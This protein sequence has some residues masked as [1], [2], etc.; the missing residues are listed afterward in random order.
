MA[1]PVFQP[2]RVEIKYFYPGHNNIAIMKFKRIIAR[3]T[4]LPTKCRRTQ[5]KFMSG[6][7]LFCPVLY[8]FAFMNACTKIIISLDIFMM[9]QSIC[10]CSNI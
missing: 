6:F 10:F 8:F 1:H 7:L 3:S 9:L 5:N 4:T 2:Q